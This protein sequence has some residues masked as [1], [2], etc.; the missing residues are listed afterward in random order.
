M[1]SSPGIVVFI[2]VTLIL[3]R[4]LIEIATLGSMNVVRDA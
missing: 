2:V 3:Y 4:R 1:W